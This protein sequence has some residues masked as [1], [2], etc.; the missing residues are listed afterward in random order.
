MI[1]AEEIKAIIK[2][3]GFVPEN[4]ESSIWS[5]KFSNHSDYLIQIQFANDVTVSAINW[6]DKIQTGTGSTSNF[7]QEETLV[8][9]E[10]VNRLLEKGYKPEDLYL[11]RVYPSGHGT[12]GR[13]DILVQNE[14]KAFLMVECKTWGREYEKE[15]KNLHKDGGQLFTYFQQDNATHHLI[16][17]T[18]RLENGK[19]E[20]KNEIVVIEKSYR[21]TSNVKDLYERWSKFTK[22]NGI[23]ESWIKPYHFESK[24]LTAKQ[25]KAI[26][27]DDSSFIFHRFLE[28]LRHNTVSD[29][30][31][32]FNKI[33]TLF[34]CK[35]KDEDRAEN[36]ELQFQWK[37]GED[38]HVSF[39][40]RLTD[41][42]KSA[43]REFL[44]KEITD[45][46]DQDFE[47]RYGSLEYTMKE[48]IKKE[49][50]KIRLQKSNEFTLKEVFD[51]ETFIENGEVLKEVVELL[52]TYQ[53][54]YIKKQ[55]FL[56]D[57]FEL[58]LTTG[59]KQES[60]QFFTPVPIARFICRSVPIKQS[61]ENKLKEGI[62]NDLLP[63]II[64]YAVGS[65]H[66]LTEVMEELQNNLNQ[67][68]PV[69]FS[70]RTQKDL[71]SW[72]INEFGWAFDYIYGIEKDYRLVKTTKVGC[73]LHGDGIANVILGDGLDSF[74]SK[75][76]KGKLS[77]QNQ[78]ENTVFDF[79]L[80]NPPYSV[81]AFKGNIKN[82]SPEKNFDLYK[83]LTDQSSEI[84]VLFIER[85]KQLLKEGGIAAI[86]LPSSIL[87]N[88][89]I[90][91]KAR[92]I[93][94]K[95]FEI[96]AITELGSN[97][98]MATG[99]NTVV[100]FL[101]RKNSYE[102]QNIQLLIEKVF[103]NLQDITI[104][105]IENAV[106]KYINYVWEGMSFADYTCLIQNDL[107]ENISNSELYKEYVKKIKAKNP[108][109]LHQK[110]LEI[111]KEKMLYFILSYKQQTVLVKTGEKEVEKRFLGYEFSFRRN[112]EGIHPIQRGKSIDECTKLFDPDILDNSTKAST[113]IQ[114]AFTGE[115]SREIDEDLKNHVSRVNLIDI[116]TF[117]RVEFEKSLNLKS[118]KKLKI[119]SK[120]EVVKLGDICEIYQPQTITSQEITKQGIYQVYGANGVIGF[121]DKFNHENSEVLVTCRGA[122]CGTINISEPKSWVTGNAMVVSP[123]N[124]KDLL[125][126]YLANILKTSDLSFPITGTAQPQIT[127][128]TLSP[129][130][131]PLPPLEIQQKIVDEIEILEKKETEIKIEIDSLKNEI[132]EIVAN[133]GGEEVSLGDI[134]TL[135]YG[136]ALNQKDRIIG[137]FPVMG[138][139]GVVGYNQSFLVEGPAVI[140][141]RKG[142]AG[143]VNWIEQNCFPIDTTYFVKITKELELKFI[144][145]KLTTLD[146]EK[147]AVGAGVPGLNRNSVYKLKTQ[148]PPL[149][150]QQKI[151]IQI[152]EI[153]G[154]I[155]KL[156]HILNQIPT[157]KQ[158]ILNKYL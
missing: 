9:L 122:T 17:Y 129:F 139:N 81:S 149:S 63:N 151:V 96:V 73:Y 123:K 64:D 113:Y 33:F 120:W 10:C 150:T 107:T 4:G 68:N 37:Q 3:L 126:N 101:R 20:Y 21:E 36:D 121:Y 26:T 108:Q 77:A 140:V 134:L 2:N 69:D 136:K 103:V 46:S 56:G 98:F 40:K 65:G 15:L 52:Q 125:N 86:I 105:G 148:I 34:L 110:I 74:D 19:V 30:P 131:I 118:K 156:E 100:L 135:E 8:V 59:L 50:A 45:F 83:N 85:T 93:I 117:D 39:Q 70:P 25:L 28:I 154:K 61:V 94:F 72:Q 127:R 24:A 158:Q 1:S 47:D 155:E 114:D 89:G 60:G 119:E 144:Y 14:G 152:Q 58:L 11:E 87:S 138:S 111:E 112:S 12:S 82:S 32:A 146:L 76:F 90:Y 75:A 18:S 153:E 128:T 91:S 102:W 23:F 95:H 57:F 132:E 157:K 143:K 51:E 44:S 142:S 49:F 66:F 41:L 5:K 7:N 43:M 78:P 6:G 141:G 35:I 124:E 55:P 115:Y 133:A 71:K 16:L 104:N 53:F 92:E 13:L 109:E 99:T 38:D 97:T 67:L 79:I 42:Y 88:S 80:S 27:Q 145:L 22:D 137:D 54:R 48:S 84:E 62:A 31:N 106:S 147:L 130:P 116:F 29:K